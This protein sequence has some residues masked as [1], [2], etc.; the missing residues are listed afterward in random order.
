[1]AADLAGLIVPGTPLLLPGVDRL[2]PEPLTH[3]RECVTAHLAGSDSWVVPLASTAVPPLLSLGGLGIDAGARVRISRECGRVGPAEL[4]TGPALTEAV[5]SLDTADA[6]HAASTSTAAV[7]A[8]LLAASAGAEVHLHAM[9]TGAA[10]PAH[11]IDC[12][13]GPLLLPIDFS[14]AAHPDAPLAPRDGADAFD[15]RLEQALTGPLDGAELRALTVQADR[16]AAELDPLGQVD[17]EGLRGA[18]E[19]AVD[20]HRVRYRVIRLEAR[21]DGRLR[22]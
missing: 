4:V 21:A 17:P 20:V 10:A 5:A 11:E 15:E 8:T 18:R 12:S 16:F 22:P 1:M 13:A 14:A 6:E 19:A 7:V 9:G 3:L 2:E